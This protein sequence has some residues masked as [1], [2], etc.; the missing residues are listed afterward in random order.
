MRNW[1]TSLG[2]IAVVTVG[3]A[4]LLPFPNHLPV[5]MMDRVATLAMSM[6]R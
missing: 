2:F 3:A 6:Q 1:R 5:I 4:L